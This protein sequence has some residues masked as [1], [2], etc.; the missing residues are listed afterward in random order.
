MLI[1]GQ[2]WSESSHVDFMREQSITKSIIS[3]SS[4]GVHLMPDN[5]AFNSSLAR[6]CNS[7]ANKLV[8]RR[9]EKFGF[10]AVLP[11]PDVN[12]ALDEIAYA[13]RELSHSGFILETNYHGTYLGDPLL[14]PIFEQLNRLKATVF[15][16]PTTPCLKHVGGRTSHSHTAI[17]LL[18]PFPN[19]L[20]EFMF[21][22][23]R[24]V[25]N[26]AHSGTLSRCP[27][28][29][30][31]TPHA[32]GALPVV[33][34]RYCKFATRIMSAEVDLGA[35]SLRSI[36]NTRFYFDLAG[37]PFPDHIH[38][39]LKI[40]GPDRLLYGSDYPFTRASLVS[41][42]AEEMKLVLERLFED[43]AVRQGV[44][45]HNARRLLQ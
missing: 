2:Q 4:P 26:L 22:T 7:F 19:P 28:I 24:A 10:W 29:T 1:N 41:E 11:L 27:D 14:D 40:I 6:Q 32:G 3:I 23:A 21:E 13:A 37:F 38:G 20:M 8:L 9:P 33:L 39:L 45:R 42:L 35:S 43:S 25:I 5:K 17:T 36:L 30:F 18:P 16:H 12:S 34:E 15:I 31:V 44:Y